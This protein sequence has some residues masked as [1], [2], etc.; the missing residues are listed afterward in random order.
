MRYIFV[1]FSLISLLSCSKENNDTRIDAGLQ[2]YY[3]SFVAEAESRNIILPDS[4]LNIKLIFTDISN[5]NILG[6]CNYNMD[7]PDVVQ[8]DRFH[9][10]TFDNETKEFVVFHE[11]GHCVLDR[12]H[13]DT[14][15]SR[16]DCTSL[17]HS[18]VGLCGFEFSGEK[19]TKYI[20]ELFMY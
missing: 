13:T 3:D 17:M 14:V 5:S 19:R 6:Q 11:L 1:V 15:D 18:S 9:W 4:I 2:E 8:I 7:A 20:D 10:R 16:G 12:G